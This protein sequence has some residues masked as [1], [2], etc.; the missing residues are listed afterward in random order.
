LRDGTSTYQDGTPLQALQDLPDRKGATPAPTKAQPGYP[1]FV[2][3]DVGQ[4]AYRIPHAVVKDDF[5]AIRRPGDAPRT[6]TSEEKASLQALSPATPGTGFV[7]PCPTGAPVRT[8]RPHAID[9]PIKYNSAGWTDKQGRVYVEESTLDADRNGTVTAEELARFVSSVTSGATV[10][11][12]YTV[13]ARQGDCVQVLTSNDLH[14]DEKPRCAPRPGQPA[15]R[16]L[17]EQ[18]GDRRDLHARAPGQVRRARLRRAQRRVELRAGCH[19]R[20]DLRLPL[21]RRPALR[22]VFFH[23]HQYANLH[24]QKGLFAA[25][26]VEPGDATWHDPRTGQETDGVGTVADIR[27]PSGPDFREITVFHQDRIPMWKGGGTGDPVQPPPSVDDFGADQGGYA[28]NYRNEPF[29]VRTSPSQSGLRKDPAYVYSSVV[30]GDPST[31]LFRAYTQ[32]PVI[33]RNVDGAHEE[34]HTFNLHGHRWLDE[35]DN[36]LSTV[37]DTQTLSLAEYFNYELSGGKPSK[38]PT[39]TART[40]GQGV[41]RNRERRAADPRRRC[42]TPR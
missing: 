33:I 24:Q 38:R 10:L 9:I 11:E 29:Q 5:A 27:S 36:P 32:D 28:L 34:V 25:M 17:L 8:Y 18:P 7:D 35:P 6:G 20:T 12:P 30:H 4:R 1:L 42:R 23:D 16:H 2:K 37:V 26:N 40:L 13:R 39:S 15:R 22:T 3:G 14:L 19:A 41:R 31:P 21:V